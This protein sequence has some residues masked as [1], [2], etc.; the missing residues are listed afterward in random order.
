[1]ISKKLHSISAR[2]LYQHCKYNMQMRKQTIGMSELSFEE[3]KKLT[4]KQNVDVNY[5][6][7]NRD[8]LKKDTDNINYYINFITP[9]P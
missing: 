8:I 6:I 3:L 1:M 2:Q 5:S 4:G 9:D 7:Y